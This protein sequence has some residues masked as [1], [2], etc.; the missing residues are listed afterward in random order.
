M[1][2]SAVYEALASLSGN[3][4]FE[5]IKGWLASK[6]EAATESCLVSEGVALHRSQGKALVLKDVISDMDDARQIVRGRK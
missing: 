3:R 2:N 5:V 1:D 6:L 4:D